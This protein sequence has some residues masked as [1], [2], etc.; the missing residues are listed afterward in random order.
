[1]KIHHRDDYAKRRAREYP[2]LTDLADALV[3]Q[4]NGDDTKLEAYLAACRAVK[5]RYPKPSEGK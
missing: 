5:E 4:A 2:P 1:M 3:H